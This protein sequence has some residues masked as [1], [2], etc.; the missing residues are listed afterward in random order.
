MLE[1]SNLYQIL[2]LVVLVSIL[3]VWFIRYNNIV[4]EFKHYQYPSWLRDFVGIL[5][6]S[7]AVM[8]QNS[9]QQV[10]QA[11]CVTLAILMSAAFFTHLKV[12][13]PLGKM[14]PSMSLLT[15]SIVLYLSF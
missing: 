10:A 9:N 14:I 15:I 8:I 6:I 2:K 4:D 11:G 13:N 5:K 3:F 7:S 1:L 12:K